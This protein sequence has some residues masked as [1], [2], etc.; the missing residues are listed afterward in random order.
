M[1]KIRKSVFRSGIVMLSLLAAVVL[2]SSVAQAQRCEARLLRVPR[3]Q[4]PRC[5]P[6]A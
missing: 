5:A 3:M 4:W 2:S 6:R 1:A